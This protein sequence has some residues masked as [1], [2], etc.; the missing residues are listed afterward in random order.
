VAAATALVVF[1]V[2]G[3][4][5]LRAA[6][7]PA[8]VAIRS[9][10]SGD[11]SV[12]PTAPVRVTFTQPVDHQAT[13][14]AV[15]F[16]PYAS[17]TPNWD[18]DTLV[19]TPQHG[20]LSPNTGYL[21]TVNRG[22]ARTSN[23]A[24][25]STDLHLAFGTAPVPGVG[26]GPT[27]PAD[28]HRKVIANAASNS[29]A[30]VARD[31]SLLLTDATAS[32]ATGGKSGLL[33]VTDHGVEALNAAAS[34]ICVSRSGDSVAYLL[35]SSEIIFANGTGGRLNDRHLTVDANS[36]LGWINDDL[37]TYVS[38]GK[39]MAAPRDGS[40]LRDLNVTVNSPAD[41]V[42][43]PGGSYAYVPG[44]GVI[45]IS[46]NLKASKARPLR[47][48]IGSPAFSGDGAT[49]VWIDNSTGKPR[50]DLAPSAGGP[51]FS[52][53]P[54]GW[55]AGD[56]FTELS[57]SPDGSHLA[58]TLTDAKKHS[59]LRVASLPDGDTLA[60]STDG[61]G[62]NLNWSPSG[63]VLTVLTGNSHIDT[64]TL[65]QAVRDRGAMFEATATA[66]ANA[67]L[68]R[69][70]GAQHSLATSDVSLPQWSTSPTRA[71]L[72]Y[73]VENADGTAKALVR[74]STDPTAA[75]PS[76]T[77]VE[78]TL[79]LGVPAAGVRPKVLKVS[80][81]N[82][83]TAAPNGPQLVHL[84][85]DAI[86]GQILLT[87]DSDLDQASAKAQVSVVTAAG[88]SAGSVDPDGGRG[89]TIKL[90]ANSGKVVV[91]IGKD[92]RDAD[93]HAFGRSFE[94]AVNAG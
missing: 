28:L 61:A 16:S 10:V 15:T 49:V 76:G 33:R 4:P 83:F 73:S 7:G 70:S 82:Q 94:L 44:A 12:D 84:D 86:P 9:A 81:G 29:E 62:A 42:I 80:A 19:L 47:G 57:V 22:V 26:P 72:V 59:D 65:P 75:N 68:S 1:L 50:L 35:G 58:Y 23:G 46:G 38:H 2:V 13:Q 78:E 71:T 20:G 55:V 27:T 6:T 43:A 74:L 56:T 60:V 25:L 89:V 64:I 67:Q 88:K 87:F 18:G 8:V 63:R 51:I 66:F 32:P 90:K 52:S 30:I 48:I 40:A 77:Q 31:G 37:V 79:T 34:A 21:L 3:F 69:D 39:L 24:A 85:T 93:G 17:V 36:P 14:A 5:G 11:V 45:T 92:L 41:L 54:D 91:R 53:T